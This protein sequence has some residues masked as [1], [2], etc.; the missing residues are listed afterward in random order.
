MAKT[1]SSS[2]SS[3]KEW[4]SSLLLSPKVDCP[5]KTFSLL[6]AKSSTSFKPYG[7]I[8][9]PTSEVLVL[10]EPLCT[11]LFYTPTLICFFFLQN[12]LYKSISEMSYDE[13]SFII[14][15]FFIAEAQFE[16]F[17]SALQSPIF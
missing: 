14:E 11:I 2:S 13:M 1:S 9:S 12:F 3:N 17:S 7:L 10:F 6:E 8:S 5:S 4:S 16:N 15:F